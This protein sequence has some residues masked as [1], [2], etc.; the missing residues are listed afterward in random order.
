MAL[1]VTSSALTEGAEL[2]RRHT[3]DG[4]NLSP[5]LAWRGVPEGAESLVVFCEDPDAPH[6]PFIHWVLFNLPANTVELPEGVPIRETL[7]AGGVQGVNSA[8]TI[9]YSGPCPPHGQTHHYHFRLVA[10]DCRLE[11]PPRAT[12][13]QVMRA[14]QGHILAEGRLVGRYRRAEARAA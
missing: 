1:Q 6:G 8:L 9:G 11:L 12:R 14:M 7:P 5:P 10:L 3:C 4:E 2:A 13:N